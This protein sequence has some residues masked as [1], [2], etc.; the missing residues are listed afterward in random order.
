VTATEATRTRITVLDLT[1][2]QVER[3][4]RESGIPLD[5]WTSA[6][7]QIALLR[8]IYGVA[9]DTPDE[10]VGRMTIRQISDAVSLE[11][12]GPADPT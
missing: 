10:A 5:K 9:T 8:R 3:I 12:E 1:V 11:D 7:S 4:E 2:D 6:P